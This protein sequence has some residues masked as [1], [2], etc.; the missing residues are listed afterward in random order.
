MTV[1]KRLL[2]I[3]DDLLDQAQQALGA[4]SMTAAVREALR[5][6]V[7][8]DRGDEYVKLLASLEPADR[9]AMWRQPGI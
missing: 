7:D 5:L 1:T 8:R 6:V 2:D 9:D 4:D 3:D